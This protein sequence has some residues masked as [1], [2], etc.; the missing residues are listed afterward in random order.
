M[1]ILSLG[2]LNLDYVYLVDHFVGGKETIASLGMEIHCGGKGLNQSVALSRAGAS[3]YHAGCIG[4]EGEPL[5]AFMQQANI[6]TEFVSRNPSKMTGHAIIQI[7]QKTGQNCI[8]TYAGANDTISIDFIDET[9]KHFEQGDF[10]AFQ[11]EVSCVEYAI[12]KCKEHGLIV[13]FNPSPLND[14]LIQSDVYQYVDYLLVNEVEGEKLSGKT[15]PREICL[16][17]RGKY[18]NCVV[19]LTLGALGV[20][21]YDGLTFL[22]HGI[23]DVEVVDTTGA[24]DTFAGYFIAAVANNNSFETAVA[25]ASKASS[26]SVTRKGAAESIPM[27]K[28]VLT[29]PLRAKQ[30][31]DTGL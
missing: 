1:K 13:A 26:L 18:P 29:A 24:G 21:L 15:Q 17:L 7:N 10:A 25:N 23:Y 19:V 16:A 3:V 28:E 31:S 27:L 12:R 22:T 20:M 6:N 4:K 30:S 2:S 5:V 8:M 11:N 14:K 9:I